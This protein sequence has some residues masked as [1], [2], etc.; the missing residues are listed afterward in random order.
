MKINFKI[1]WN[2]CILCILYGC[3]SISN[4]QTPNLSESSFIVL[5]NQDTIYTKKIRF[6]RKYNKIGYIHV[7]KINGEKVIFPYDEIYQLH[8]YRKARD[9]YV[10]E[11]V[12]LTPNNPISY[13]AMDVIINKGKVKLYEHDPTNWRNTPFVISDT[14]YGYV[15]TTKEYEELISEL[16]KCSVFFEKFLDKEERDKVRLETLINYYNKNCE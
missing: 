8:H 6:S 2:V 10:E 15:R 14:Y 1:V 9:F 16:S 4:R 7:K 13:T 11:M 3:A 5:K 12:M